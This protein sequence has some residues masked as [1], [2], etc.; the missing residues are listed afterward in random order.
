MDDATEKFQT[1]S[2]MLTASAVARKSN[3]ETPNADRAIGNTLHRWSHS[4]V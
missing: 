2:R 1:G 3:V 4:E